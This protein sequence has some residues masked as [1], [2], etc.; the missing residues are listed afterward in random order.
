MERSSLRYR[1]ADRESDYFRERP[2]PLGVCGVKR[3]LV[4][5]AS[6][7]IGRHSLPHLVARGFEIHATA[8]RRLSRS[9]DGVQWHQADL[10]DS[11]IARD[12]LAEVKPSH[13]LH[14]AW[15][16]EPGKY[17]QSDMNSQWYRAGIELIHAFASS[18][19]HRAVFAGTC[20]EY[21]LSYGYCSEASTPCLPATPYG[22][23]KLALAQLVVG[24]PP[25]GLSTAWGRDISPI[26]SAASIRAASSR[27]LFFPCGAANAR[28]ARMDARCAI[29][30]MSTMSLR[31]SS[32]YWIAGPKE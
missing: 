22:I 29:L 21:D 31:H 1:M 9:N 25:A 12:L 28:D 14:F 23:S 8:H 6:G 4:T 32:R 30:C 3:V 7:F 26:W 18:G 11:R 15:Y 13:L 16:A 5:G 27:P 17:Q 19:G 10:L 20:F 24:S 2:N